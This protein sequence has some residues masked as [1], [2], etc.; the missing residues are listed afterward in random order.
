MRGIIIC[1]IVADFCQRVD[2][3]L[4]LELRSALVTNA[5]G[6]RSRTSC[7]S[8]R[9]RCKAFTRFARSGM[10]G[11]RFQITRATLL[12]LRDRECHPLDVE[13]PRSRIDPGARSPSTSQASI[14]SLGARW[15][16]DTA[17]I[18]I[19]NSCLE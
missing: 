10:P 6:N 7:T 16:R 14:L 18:A 17:A 2:Q 4:V 13:R 1:G 9:A 19:V 8:K 11:A 5:R 3:I 12:R 15:H